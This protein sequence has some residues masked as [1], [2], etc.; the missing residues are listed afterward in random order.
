MRKVVHKEYLE[1]SYHSDLCEG[2]ITQGNFQ[3]WSQGSKNY[4]NFIR[5]LKQQCQQLEI[6]FKYA[7][8]AE[9]PRSLLISYHVQIRQ[10][11][12]PI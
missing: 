4:M 7:H 8:T 6:S 12:G 9:G 3:M 11:H 10:L 1:D 5:S 2:E